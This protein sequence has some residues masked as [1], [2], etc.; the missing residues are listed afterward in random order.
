MLEG[1]DDAGGGPQDIDDD[2]VEFGAGSDG[3]LSREEQDVDTHIVR[4]RGPEVGAQG[5]EGR[6]RT[7]G[8]RW[9]SA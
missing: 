2:G 1:D 8:W 3:D 6:P 5:S 7:T 9:T 4:G